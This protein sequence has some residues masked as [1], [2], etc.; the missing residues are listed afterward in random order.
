MFNENN[1]IANLNMENIPEHVLENRILIFNIEHPENKM[2]SPFMRNHNTLCGV[3]KL[4]SI[5]QVNSEWQHIVELSKNNINTNSNPN[6]NNETNNA[7]N[8]ET[9]NETN[10]DTNN[11]TN[12][13]TINNI[14]TGFSILGKNMISKEHISELNDEVSKYGVCFNTPDVVKS[15]ER[16][17]ADGTPE[18]INTI[19]ININTLMG[20]VTNRP[21]TFQGYLIYG[22][23]GERTKISNP[24]YKILK[25]L[26]GNR[27]VVIEQWNIKNLFYLYWRLIKQNIVH[28]FIKEFDVSGGWTYHQLFMWF[29]TLTRAYANYL[30]RCYHHSFVKKDMNKNDIPYSMKPLCGELHKMYMANKCP[31]TNTMVEQFIFQM[32]TGK[33]FWRLFTINNYNSIS[34]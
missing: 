7:T 20:I 5:E 25:Q 11:A 24:Q 8:N 23:N 28:Q 26:K 2:I 27:P 14:R 1:V 21:K 10:N 13:E 16:K 32:P 33:V 19:D 12:N 15:F 30:F 31:I 22:I 34:Q 4:K 18:V 3:Y 6:D 17:K 9:N 29:S